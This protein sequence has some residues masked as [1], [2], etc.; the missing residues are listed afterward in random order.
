M[1]KKA[2]YSWSAC[3]LM[4]LCGTVQVQAQTA[5]QFDSAR[6]KLPEFASLDAFYATLPAV[7]PIRLERSNATW[8]SA[9]PL[10][11]MSHPHNHPTPVPYLWEVSYS[12]VPDFENTRAFYGCSDWHSAVNS[13]WTLVKIL[14]L[15]PDLPTAGIIR[16]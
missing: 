16:Q 15:V 9:M 8:L 10:S 7:D 6:A 3:L 4:F 2:A 1:Q 13:A 12:P 11:C 14:K 5:A